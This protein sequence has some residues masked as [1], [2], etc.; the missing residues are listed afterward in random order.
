M[1]GATVSTAVG[2][3]VKEDSMGYLRGVMHGVLIGGA[4][5][6]LYA[7]KPGREM[8]QDLS[9]RFSRVREQVQ[10]VIDQAQGVVDTTRPQVEQTIA[11]AQ[12]RISRK[13][14]DGPSSRGYAGPA[15]AEPG[16][17]VS[18]GV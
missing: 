18:P 13:G 9:D 12:Q 2:G 10:P 4:V 11:K 8:R 7:P 3:S 5:A 6:L 16:S 1:I 14:G 15:G 17:N